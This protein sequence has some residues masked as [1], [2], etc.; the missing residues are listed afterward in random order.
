MPA[1][2]ASSGASNGRRTVSSG[3]SARSHSSM[4]SASFNRSLPRISRPATR[5]RETGAAQTVGDLRPRTVRDIWC[6]RQ[7]LQ[8]DRTNRKPRHRLRRD[9]LDGR[10]DLDPVGLLPACSSKSSTST[11]HIGSPVSLS[12]AYTGLSFVEAL[13]SANGL[14]SL[15]TPRPVR[16]HLRAVDL[17]RSLNRHCNPI[18]VSATYLC[19]DMC[20]LP[21]GERVERSTGR[22]K[23]LDQRPGGVRSSS[24]RRWPGPVSGSP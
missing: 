22:P 11:C 7:P 23:P 9:R 15:T 16:K 1:V 6:D 12:R 18:L 5:R 2:S 21:H 10:R 17:D 20:H 3:S 14:T 24:R 8:H 19:S 4:C 13:T